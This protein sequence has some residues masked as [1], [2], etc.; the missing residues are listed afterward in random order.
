MQTAGCGGPVLRR[1][2]RPWGKVTPLEAI[3]Q[4]KLRAHSTAAVETIQHTLH[5]SLRAF[6]NRRQ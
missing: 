6:E 1:L 2:G 3:K 4:A 5:Q